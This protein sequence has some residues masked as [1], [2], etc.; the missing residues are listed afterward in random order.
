M[1]NSPSGIS[2]LTN[3]SGIQSRIPGS[4]MSK[5]TQTGS[6]LATELYLACFCTVLYGFKRNK[7]KSLCRVL[8]I[9]LGFSVQ[10]FHNTIP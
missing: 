2:K 6:K 3:L 4:D 7:I 8:L 9:F 10:V 5:L 1:L